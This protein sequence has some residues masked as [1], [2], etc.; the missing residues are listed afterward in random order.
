RLAAL[1]L[2]PRAQARLGGQVLA[3]PAAPSAG[4]AAPRA[5][6]CSQG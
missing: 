1:W 5:E 4:H 3:L 2:Q 6:H